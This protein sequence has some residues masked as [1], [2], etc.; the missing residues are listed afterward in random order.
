MFD[1]WACCVC[2]DGG[3]GAGACVVL[4]EACFELPMLIA[5]I[6]AGSNVPSNRVD[7]FNA[8]SGLWSAASLSEGRSDLTATSLPN[9]GLAIFAGGKNGL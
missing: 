2:C 8:I 4:M 3:S 7:I 6:L 5:A 9:Q 1:D